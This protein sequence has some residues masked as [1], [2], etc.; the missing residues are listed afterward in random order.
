MLWKLARYGRPRHV[1]LF[2]PVSLGDDVLCT[3]VLHELRRRS[4]QRLWMMSNNPGLF[5]GN[6]DVDRV[7]PV[8]VHHARLLARLGSHLIRPLVFGVTD[9]GARLVPPPRHVIAE[10]CRVAGL[11]GEVSLR[12]YMHLSPDERRRG[13]RAEH[14]V[15]VH[16]SGRGA[17][18]PMSNKDWGPDRFQAVVDRLRGAF[19]CVQLGGPT[20]P[21]LAGAIDLRGQTSLR[22]SA[23]IVSASDAVICQVGFLMHLA[24][25]TDVPAVVIYGGV[26]DPA[27]TGYPANE[28]LT[29]VP[30]CGVCWL[31]N[32]CPQQQ[33]C[34]AAISVDAV[35]GAL[36]RIVR[37]PAG[38]LPVAA[39]RL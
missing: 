5:A 11:G 20:D 24:R 23:A 17:R 38:P 22:E 2:G 25:A 19:Q 28:N 4:A 6:P 9:G 8:D 34:M 3:A 39:A 26:E 32:N 7:V 12:P 33:Q 27:V 29:N 36:H 21:P 14:Q 16:S 10:M 35:V 13:R 15:V 1:V 31:P 18:Y 37:R 30:P